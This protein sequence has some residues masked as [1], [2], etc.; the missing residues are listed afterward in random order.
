MY[1]VSSRHS[2]DISRFLNFDSDSLTRGLSSFE[3]M[4]SL[5]QSLVCI[6]VC[7]EREL[8]YAGLKEKGMYTVV[9]VA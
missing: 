3:T 4:R 1:K 2:I 7:I 6:V 9:L 5:S 8:K